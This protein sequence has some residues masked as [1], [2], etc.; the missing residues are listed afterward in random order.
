[1]VGTERVKCFV[2]FHEIFPLIDELPDDGALFTGYGQ[3]IKMNIR[4]NISADCLN[5]IIN[6][7]VAP[8]Y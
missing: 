3:S 7:D 6:F 4:T 5:N 8:S 1:M 2:P